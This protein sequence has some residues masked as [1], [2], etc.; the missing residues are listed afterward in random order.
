MKKKQ[1][2]A[3]PP[4]PW[5]MAERRGACRALNILAFEIGMHS[6]KTITVKNVLGRIE[7]V[8]RGIDPENS[9]HN[10]AMAV[11]ARLAGE[12]LAKKGR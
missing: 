2:Q 12:G 7:E 6:R 5:P 11:L 1:S 3:V 4:K 9:V 8:R 10:E